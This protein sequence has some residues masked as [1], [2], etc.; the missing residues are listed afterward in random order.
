MKEKETRLRQDPDG[1]EIKID[2][3]EIDWIE[4]DWNEIRASSH[5]FNLFVQIKGMQYTVNVR[6]LNVRILDKTGLLGL[7]KSFSLT[8]QTKFCSVYQT[9]L[10]KS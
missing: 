10:L 9:E 1:I 8:I 6:N 5:N 2:W 7:L 3:I 4:I